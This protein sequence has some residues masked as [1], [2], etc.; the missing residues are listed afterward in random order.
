MNE[1]DNELIVTDDVPETTSEIL[2]EDTT[3][4]SEVVDETQEETVQD[5][6]ISDEDIERQIEERANKLFED[7][8][9]TRLIR[10]RIKQE[11][12]YNKELEKYKYLESIINSGLGTSNLDDAISKTTD[13]YKEQGIS[14]PAYNVQS[15]LTERQ[16]KILAEAEANEIKQCG[17]KEMENEANRIAGIPLDKRTTR[18]K[19]VFKSLAEELISRRNISELKAKGYDAKILDSDDFN[20]FKSKFS[21][22]EPISDIYE[23]YQKVNGTAK[24]QEPRSPGSAKDTASTN[25]IKE[26]YTPE[27]VR[28]FTEEDLSNPN[29]MKAVELSMNKWGKNSN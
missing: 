4:T 22:N 18:E 14:I 2:N 17:I 20:K 27:E 8:I 23:M 13:F 5:A 28:K 21:T 16:E 26:F 12:K 25:E 11:E 6:Q 7:K 19:L 9:E 24:K 3:D 1:E 29:L 10:D 15:N